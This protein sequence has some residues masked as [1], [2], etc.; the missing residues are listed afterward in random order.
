[1]NFFLSHFHQT[2]LLV[3]AILAINTVICSIVVLAFGYPIRI[4]IFA[5]LILAEIGEFSFVLIQTGAAHNLIG[6]EAY[7][8]LIDVVA[9]TLLLTPLIYKLATRVSLKVEALAFLKGKIKFL[10]G[11][12]E[13]KIK[14]KN[15]IIVVGFG[16]VG[17]NLAFHLNK[18]GMPYVVTEMNIKTVNDYSKKGFPIYFGDAA[19]SHV[20]EKMGI[21][22]ASAIAVTV[23]DPD[24]IEA[25]VH[26]AKKL[27]PKIAILAR[28]RF[29]SEIGGL[30][31]KG[32]TEVISEELEVSQIITERLVAHTLK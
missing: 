28:V 4:A 6:N 12:E 20:L 5:A 17:Q 22:H 25:L 16:H 27:N 1:M 29:V 19:S 10:A 11:K 31:A 30:L 21:E 9:V 18:H 24:G 23:L 26:E 3:V 2:M 13:E 7:Q 32:V 14:L 15:H 8:L